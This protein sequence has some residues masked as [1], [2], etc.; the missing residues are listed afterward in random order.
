[1]A[2]RCFY[3]HPETQ[4]R[5]SLGSGDHPFHSIYVPG[6]GYLDPA[7][8]NE[9]WVEPRQRPIL[10]RREA[11]RKM[12]EMQK[13]VPPEERT[14]PPIIDHAAARAAG[15]EAQERV[16]AH[17]APEWKERAK[18]AIEL[19]ARTR[20]YVSADDLWEI[21]LDK[22]REPRALGPIFTWAAKRHLIE[23]TGDYQ[24]SG[25]V[26]NHGRPSALW[27]SLVYRPSLVPVPMRNFD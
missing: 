11:E 9:E 19:V 20:E 3:I 12:R 5:C 14:G 22:P 17:A 27:R 18:A 4:R 2:E 6:E 21:G 7:P 25:Q 15:R 10:A 1:M 24:P 16:D 13:R 26:S 23:K 8:A